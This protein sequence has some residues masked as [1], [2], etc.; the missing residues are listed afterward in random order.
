M[1]MDVK[2]LISISHKEKQESH[3]GPKPWTLEAYFRNVSKNVKT[4]VRNDIP[5]ICW[6]IL[7]A[8]KI[9]KM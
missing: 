1:T 5:M 8:V 7:P 3:S 2:S 9:T 4:Y 6:G